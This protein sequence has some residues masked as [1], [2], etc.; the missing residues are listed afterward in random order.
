MINGET[1]AEAE[2]TVDTLANATE[3]STSGPAFGPERFVEECFKAYATFIKKKIIEG[4]VGDR[5]RRSATE[6][7]PTGKILIAG[8]L[9]PLIEDSQL[10]VI[11]EKYVVRL[12]SEHKVTQR[13]FEEDTRQIIPSSPTSSASSRI[14]TPIEAA[15]SALSTPPSS[16]MSSPRVVKSTMPHRRKAVYDLL[17]FSDVPLCD[18]ST[19]ISM[20]LRWNALLSL[21]CAEFPDILTFVDIGPSMVLNN[22]TDFTPRFASEVG[23]SRWADAKDPTNIHPSFEQTLPLWMAELTRHGVDTS[24]FEI[25]VDLQLSARRYEDEKEVRYERA[26]EERRLAALR[27]GLDASAKMADEQWEETKAGEAG[28]AGSVGEVTSAMGQVAL[29]G[30]I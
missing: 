14:S 8:A 10:N 5:I 22:P 20:T 9:P 27:E 23:R 30:N 19:R 18:L 21:F 13:Q 29:V 4:A 11:P 1:K 24:R 16:C 28:E 15:A 12:E 2:Y 17:H 6:R 7:K 3:T 25:V 26:S